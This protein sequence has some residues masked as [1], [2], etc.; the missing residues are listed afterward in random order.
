MAGYSKSFDEFNL[1]ANVFYNIGNQ[2]VADLN[3]ARSTAGSNLNISGKFKNTYGVAIEPGYNFNKETLGYLKLAYVSTSLSGT[4]T[5][6]EPG[7]PAD[8]SSQNIRF[9]GI[10]YGVG[11]KRMIDKNLFVGADFLYTQYQSKTDADQFTTKPNQMSYMIG[12]GYKF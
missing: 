5:Y 4:G 2:S 8:S 10:G 12:V 6:T 9:N 3:S 7:E 11:V 1:A